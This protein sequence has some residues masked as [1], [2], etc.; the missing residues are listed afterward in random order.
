M[1]D[2]KIIKD[3]YDQHAS[4]QNNVWKIN[5][6]IDLTNTNEK[7]YT[8]KMLQEIVPTGESWR[9]DCEWDHSSTSATTSRSAEEI[10][11][12]INDILNIYGKNKNIMVYQLDISIN[13]PSGH[14]RKTET[15]ISLQHA[16][17]MITSQ[18]QTIEDI[19]HSIRK[20]FCTK[21]FGY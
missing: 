19:D 21:M 7:K 3:A 20:S 18:K 1:F 9:E 10:L 15:K 16:Q 5:I 6:T 2:R 12:N 17:E 11:K 4:N 8:L 13:A 14:Y